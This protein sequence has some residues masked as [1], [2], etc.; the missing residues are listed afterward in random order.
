MAAYETAVTRCSTPWAPWHVI[1]ANHHW[2][3]DALVAGILLRALEGLKLA[4]PKLAVPK[5]SV[6]ID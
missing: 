1:P 2:Y 3:R 4:Y 5:S 6:R